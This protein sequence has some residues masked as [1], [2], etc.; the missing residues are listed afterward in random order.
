MSDK[1]IGI[2]V[3]FEKEISKEYLETICQMITSIKG[4]TDARP[5]ESTI[6]HWFAYQ[7]ARHDLIKKLYEVLK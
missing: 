5:K 1:Y 4:V 2:Y 7:Q 3:T 6:D